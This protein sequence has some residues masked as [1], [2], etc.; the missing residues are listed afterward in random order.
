MSGGSYPKKRWMVL[1]IAWGSF[2][3]IGMAWYVMP[4]LQ[5]RLRELY[6]LS[7]SQFRLCLTAPFLVAGFLAIPGGMIAD[8]FGIRRAAAA[9]IAIAGVGYLVRSM[10]GGFGLLLGAMLLVGVGVGLLMPNLPKL[11]NLWFPPDETGLATGIYNTAIMGGFATGLV[12]APSLPGWATGNVVLAG[13]VLALAV[14]FFAVVRDAPPGHD[15]PSTPFVEGVQRAVASRNTWIAALAVFAGFGGMVALQGQLPVGLLKVYG[16]PPGVGG[17]I[18]SMLTYS[19][20]L[21]S[22]TIP[23]IATR[24]D[25]RR[26]VLLSVSL[27]FGIIEFAVWLSGDPTLLFAG[28]TVAGY[29]A[30]GALPILMEVPAW[31]PQ[32]EESPV[33][34]RHVG[35]ASGVMT[36][37]MN[38]GGFAGLPFIVGPIINARGYTVGFLVAMIVFAFQGIFGFFL[39]FP[40]SASGEG[41]HP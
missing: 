5:P 23:P 27:A 36:S 11:V 37:L 25:R 6:G 19:G 1:G 30:G 41:R 32:L 2:F 22:L 39:S 33:Q 29:L 40:E 3:A 34:Q 26:M 12:I 14:A 38:L 24:I 31:L 15:V 35:G 9:G 16:I 13:L 7:A 17:Q 28:T 21:G 8:R 20:I 10:T 4:T 18:A